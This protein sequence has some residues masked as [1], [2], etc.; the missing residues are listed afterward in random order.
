MSDGFFLAPLPQR[1]AM[2]DQIELRGPEAHHLAV[3]RRIRA[4]ET[5]TV[6]DG[7][8]RGA[9][10]P[11]TALGAGLVSVAVAAVLAGE[12][13][14][15]EITLV[16]ALPKNERAQQAVDLMTELGVDRIVPWQAARSIVRW[17]GERGAKG[18]AKWQAW[19]GQAAQ[20]A[21]RLT[22]PQ[23]APPAS[24]AEV[25]QLLAAAG[26]AIIMHE[27][28]TTPIAA[29]PI[30][31]SSPLVCVIGPEGGIA[32]DELAR[33]EAAGARPW[34]MGPTVLRTTVAGGVA[35]AQLRL[36]AMQAV[37]AA[38][39]GERGGEAAGRVTAGPAAGAGDSG[40]VG[41]QDGSPVRGG[42]E[43]RGEGEG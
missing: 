20:Q 9:S 7:A 21:R 8:G 26:Q 27:S 18:R 13:S 6:S 30:D 34:S 42:P 15:P 2:G 28:A 5:V 3:V 36:L 38:S 43:N 29:R 39:A 40:V 33:F 12:P 31:P 11:V 37:L 17:Q 19:A 35:V 23:V 25:A 10:G 1:L 16:Q 4:G 41:P 32:P 14:R 24:T 22:V